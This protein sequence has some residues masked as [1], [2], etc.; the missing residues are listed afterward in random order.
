MRNLLY[1]ASLALVAKNPQFKALYQYLRNRQENPLK[2]KQAL[3]VIACKL[4]RAMFALIKENRLYDPE[5][6][7]GRVSAAAVKIRGLIRR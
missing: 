5:K 3:V 6:S 7:F 4:L 2:G 1:Q